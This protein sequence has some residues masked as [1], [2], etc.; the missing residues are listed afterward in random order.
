M[1]TTIVTGDQYREIDRKFNEIKRQLNQN[2]GYP[3]SFELLR[4]SLQNITEGKFDGNIIDPRYEALEPFVII[5]PN[6]YVHKNRLSTFEK[7]YKKEFY[8]Y[9]D[10]ITDKNFSNPSVVLKSGRKLLVKPFAIKPG[11]RITSEDNLTL[12]KSQNGIFTGA[13][14][15]SLVYELAKDKLLKGKW[16]ISFDKKDRLWKDAVGYHGVPF[17]HRNSVGGFEFNLGYFEGG[18]DGGYCVLCFCDCE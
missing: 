10:A 14:G 11:K 7:K 18:W 9:N 13:Q 4:Q 2:E 17:V 1:A 12:I 5:V 3:F 8:F 6:D 16:Y 15:A